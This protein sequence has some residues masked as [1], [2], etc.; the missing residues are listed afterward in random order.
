MI[1]SFFQWLDKF[2][3]ASYAAKLHTMIQ[4]AHM[5]DARAY[6]QEEEDPNSSTSHLSVYGPG[7]S[8]VSLTTTIG[9]R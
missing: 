9:R 8:A 2:Q 6:T 7:G 5:Q 4:D 1:P 3:N